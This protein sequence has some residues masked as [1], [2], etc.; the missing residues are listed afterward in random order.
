MTK[1]SIHVTAGIVLRDGQ[2]FLTKRAQTAHQGGKWEFPGG[3]VEQGES[4]E[5]ALVRELDEEIGIKVTTA[6]PF[7]TICHDYPEKKVILD[8]ALVSRFEGEPS[9]CEGQQFDWFDIGA[10]AELDFPDANQAVVN[11]LLA[12]V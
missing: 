6:T 10:I 5:Q 7:M 11:K 4:I 9:G 3:K 2:V 1:K 12:D 8:F